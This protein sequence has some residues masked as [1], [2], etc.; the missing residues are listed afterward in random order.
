M[1]GRWPMIAAAT[2]L[3]TAGCTIVR[4]DGPARVTS[5]HLGTL[6]IEPTAPG[7]LVYRAAGIGVVPGLRGATLGANVETAALVSD[8]A[9]CRIILF[10]P[11]PR[12]AHALAAALAPVVRD[13][14][15]CSLGER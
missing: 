6:R 15:I 13:R 5:V 9:A 11:R 4:I 3:A 8:P 14:D 1:M 7:I 10:A 12:D 2:G